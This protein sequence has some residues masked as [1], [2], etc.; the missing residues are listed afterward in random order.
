MIKRVAWLLVSCL[1]VLTLVLASCAEETDTGGTVTTEDKGQTVTVGG[2]EDDVS[3]GPGTAT[4]V[5]E[6]QNRPQYGGRLTFP[7]PSAPT[8]WNPG[9]VVGTSA[10]QG[11]IVLE[12]MLGRNWEDGEAG[13]GKYNFVG[14]VPEWGGVGGNLVESW[15]IL[16]IGIWKLHVRQGVHFAYHPEFEASKLVGGREMTA[17]DVAYSIEWMRDTESS[18]GMMSEPALFSNATPLQGKP[19]P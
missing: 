6:E 12:Q 7:A 15:E 8:A 3:T 14:G 16:G 4:T 5:G 18:A 11:S 19:Q 10:G 13:S 9:A 17:E 1:M 2:E